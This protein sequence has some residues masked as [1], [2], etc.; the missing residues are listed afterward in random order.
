M[1]KRSLTPFTDPVWR[2]PSRLVDGQD[3]RDEEKKYGTAGVDCRTRASKNEKIRTG[4]GHFGCHTRKVVEV[5]MFISSIAE[6][7]W[8]LTRVRQS[9]GEAGSP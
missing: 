4:G 8:S 3:C 1:E 5:F 9:S 2:E 6:Y 7:G